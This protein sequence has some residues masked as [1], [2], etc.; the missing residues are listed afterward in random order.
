MG[1]H[2]MLVGATVTGN[3]TAEII[4]DTGKLRGRHR[5]GWLSWWRTRLQRELDTIA[6]DMTVA[7]LEDLRRWLRWPEC[8]RAY[9]PPPRRIV[10]LPR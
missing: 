6:E 4:N 1:Y 2:L 3:S 5:R 9:T 8:E 7:D 10:V